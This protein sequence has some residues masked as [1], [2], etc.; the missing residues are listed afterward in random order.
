MHYTIIPSLCYENAPTI[1]SESF[2]RGVPALVANIGGA[3]EGVE[4]GINGFI[5][6][7]SNSESL[8]TAIKRAVHYNQYGLLSSRARQSVSGRSC[9]DYVEYLIQMQT[10]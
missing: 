3:A 7:P 2:S 10:Q 8:R 4:D 6:A 5:F 1:L 9:A